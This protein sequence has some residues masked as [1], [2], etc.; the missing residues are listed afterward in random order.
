MGHWRGR[1]VIGGAGGSLEGYVGHWR[2]RW[3]S[4]GVGGSLEGYVVGCC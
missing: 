2:G 4:G 1:W 3:V